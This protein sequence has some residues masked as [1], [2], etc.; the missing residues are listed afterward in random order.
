[1]SNKETMPVHSTGAMREKLNSARYDLMPARVVNEAYARV[2][3]F[4][5]KKYTKYWE[6]TWD[7]LLNVEHVAALSLTLQKDYVDHVIS[8]LE[9]EYA[10]N[11]KKNAKSDQK[12][13]TFVAHAMTENSEITTLSMHKDKNTTSKTGNLIILKN[14]LPVEV[15]HT[16]L[17]KLI[18][19]LENESKTNGSKLICSDVV[20][21]ENS[22]ILSGKLDAQSADQ[23]FICIGITITLPENTEESFVQNITTGLDF[24]ETTSKVLKKLFNI[25]EREILVKHDGFRN[26]ER[27]LPV[28]QIADSLQRHL[29]AYMEG[30]DKDK[31]SGLS[32]LDHVLWNAV[33]LCFNEYHKMCDDRIPPITSK[34]D[35][36]VILEKES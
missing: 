30:Q 26:W 29:W 6:S 32:H 3:N 22:M 17:G 28:S 12:K 7:A 21:Q 19:C 18:L 10:L 5:A 2:A 11:V 35:S 13:T 34:V 14:M 25:S 33:A 31:D 24:W 16:N 1:M 8:N 27:G 15:D 20:L 23:N 4:G 36:E 9:S